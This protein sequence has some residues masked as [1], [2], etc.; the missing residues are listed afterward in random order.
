MPLYMLDTN[1]CI[2]LMKNQPEA[3]ARRFALCRVGDV[4]ISAI[5]YAELVYGVVACGNGK[6]ERRRLA[7]LIAAIPVAPFNCAAAFAYGPVRLATRLRK[8]DQLDKL[9]AAHALALD[10][11]LVTNNVRDF[12]HYPGIK[13]DNW[14]DS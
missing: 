11:V 4:V 9:I 2:Y 6:R 12:D 7:A 13:I 14:L 8:R 10:I 1:M 3:I 5:T